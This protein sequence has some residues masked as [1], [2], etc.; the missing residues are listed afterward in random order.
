MKKRKTPEGVEEQLWSELKEDIR[1]AFNHI[2]TAMPREK[3][4]ESI[5]LLN[6]GLI[7]ADELPGKPVDWEKMACEK[8]GFIRDQLEVAAEI[9]IGR[10]A[11]DRYYWQNIRGYSEREFED[12]WQSS[13]FN[14]LYK[15]TNQCNEGSNC[16]N[17]E[18][19]KRCDTQKTILPFLLGFTL[20]IYCFSLLILLLKISGVL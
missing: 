6:N 10:K 16:G 20:G 19:N 12:F 17:A 9:T 2:C 11:I 4:A 18:G 1:T 5:C 14:L 13:H 8:K 7:W 15:K 3:I